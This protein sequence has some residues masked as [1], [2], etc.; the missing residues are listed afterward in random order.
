[1]SYLSFSTKLFCW[2]CLPMYKTLYSQSH[3]IG[4][5]SIFVLLFSTSAW[6]NWAALFCYALHSSSWWQWFITSCCTATIAFL[7]ALFPLILPECGTFCFMS[8]HCCYT[9]IMHLS[10]V[11]NDI[12]LVLKLKIKCHY[13]QEQLFSCTSFSE[14]QFINQAKREF[15]ANA[16]TFSWSTLW[17]LDFHHNRIE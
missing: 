8:C 2:L 3:V 12:V 15:C 14:L 5:C 13:W 4:L 17:T 10:I 7:S 9:Y 16:S 1:M 6:H 11:Y